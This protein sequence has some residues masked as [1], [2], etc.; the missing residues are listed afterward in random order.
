M[1]LAGDWNGDGFDTI[2]VFRPSNGVVFLNNT[3]VGGIA[4]IAINY[5]LPGDKPV[6]GDWNNDGIDSIGVYRG[7]TFYLRNSNTAGFA[8]LV[9]TLSEP[10]D[11]PVAGNWDG[12]P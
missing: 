8:D 1:G 11:L 6:V 5:G 9:A 4:D 10:G 3:N 2:G 7:D 12:L